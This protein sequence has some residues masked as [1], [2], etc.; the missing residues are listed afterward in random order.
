MKKVLFIAN[1]FVLLSIFSCSSNY[2][3]IQ[4]LNENIETSNRTYPDISAS[5]AKDIETIGTYTT[6]LGVYKTTCTEK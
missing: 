2:E 5:D 4:T 1:S 6:S 3:C